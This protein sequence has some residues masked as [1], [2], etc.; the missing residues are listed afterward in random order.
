[1]SGRWDLAHGPWWA[2][3]SST[4]LFLF[5]EVQ[6]P[7]IRSLKLCTSHSGVKGLSIPMYKILEG[8]MGI[9]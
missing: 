6:K 3:L 7:L 4:Q 5:L 9:D 1:M 8:S 2:N